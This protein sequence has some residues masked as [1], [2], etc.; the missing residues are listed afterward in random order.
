MNVVIFQL[1][2]RQSAEVE[3]VRFIRKRLFSSVV[4]S[5]VVAISQPVLGKFSV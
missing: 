3:L 1:R 5:Y 2:S 4:H